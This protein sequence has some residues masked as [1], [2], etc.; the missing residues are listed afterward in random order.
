LGIIV[1]PPSA[2]QDDFLLAEHSIAYTNR[3]L[4]GVL[5][6]RVV[7]EGIPKRTKSYS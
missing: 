6:G 4:A 1:D 5:S 7:T 3:G 2:I